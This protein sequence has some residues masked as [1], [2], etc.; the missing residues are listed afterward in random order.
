MT[1]HPTA[2]AIARAQD[3]L[4]EAQS[5]TSTLDEKSGPI[6]YVAG[7]ASKKLGEAVAML[8]KCK[9]H[10][11]KKI[12]LAASLMIAAVAQRRPE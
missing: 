2:V 7:I 1:N 8:N 4:V 10:P 3:V 6:Q 9:G 11:M 12:I 5:C